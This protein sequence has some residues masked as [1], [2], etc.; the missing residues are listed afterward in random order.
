MPTMRQPRGDGAVGGLGFADH[1]HAHVRVVLAD[2]DV[3][4]AVQQRIVQVPQPLQFVLDD[5]QFGHAVVQLD[6]FRF[7]LLVLAAEL[8]FVLPEA[9]QF[10]FDHAPAASVP[11]GCP[12]GRARRWLTICW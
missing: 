1:G 7:G 12:P 11:A 3:G 2:V 6:G 9:G 4:D 8:V 5:P 10:L